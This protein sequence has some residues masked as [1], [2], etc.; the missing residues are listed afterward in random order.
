M[1][2]SKKGAQ[3]KS[4]LSTDE[5]PVNVKVVQIIRIEFVRGKGTEED[6]ARL[7]EQYWS[8]QGEFLF[9][10]DVTYQRIL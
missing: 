8:I 9:E 5:K 10:K 1:E 2:F 3:M 6:P 4:I 7:V